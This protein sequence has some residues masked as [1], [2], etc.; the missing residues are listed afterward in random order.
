MTLWGNKR[1]KLRLDRLDN[2][3]EIKKRGEETEKKG[4]V[5]EVIKWLVK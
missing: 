2:L 4:R 5:S 1:N 3:S